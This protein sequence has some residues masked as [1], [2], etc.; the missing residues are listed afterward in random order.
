M[1]DPDTV[2]K[3]QH[4]AGQ[5]ASAEYLVLYS[6]RMY[7]TIPRLPDRYPAGAAYYRALFDGSLG[8]EL[9]YTAQKTP[10]LLGIAYD[11]DPFARIDIPPPEGFA[12]HRG[13][14]AT[15]GFGWA[16]ESFTVYDHPKVLVFRNTGRLDA[17]EIL[18]RI[19]DV[20]P[21]QPP[22]VRLLLSD[23]EAERQ[24]AGG[25]WT[26]V[27]FASG[28]P[29]G[30]TPFYWLLAA[31]AFGLAA[32]PLGLVVFRPLPDRGYLLIK[33]LGLLLVAAVAWLLVS[34]GVATFSRWS[35][36]V[37]LAIVGALSAAA[38]WRCRVEVS[39]FFRARWRHVVAMEVLFLVA[40]FAFLFV[41]S[42]NPDLW[43]PWRGGEKPMDFAYLNAVAR[44]TVMPPYDPWF[45]GGYLN[46]YYFGQ[47]IVASLIRVTGIAPSVAYN[48]AVPLLFALV[49]GGTF[50]IAYSLAEGARRVTG[51]D[52]PPRW[53]WSP[54]GA[55]LFAVVV[56]LIA[57]NM[58]GVT[59]LVLGARR[60]LLH[61][62]P[63]GAFDFWRSS[64]MMA[65]QVSGITE[66]PYF[67]FLFAD[68]HAHLI[69]IP[70]ALLAVGLSLA[71]FLRTGQPGR[72]WLETWG[73]LA[74]LGIVVGSLRI[75]NSW[76]YPTQLVIAAGAVVGGELLGGRR[77]APARPVAGIVKAGFAVLVGY[78][79]F[80]PFH[81]RF[82][83]F[84]SGV[85]VSRFQTPLW[86]YLAVHGVFIFILLGYLA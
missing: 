85:D 1:Y 59:Q 4:I 61:G 82:E 57:G 15:I 28:V 29:S 86:R 38:W 26:D 2:G 45:A 10:D 75:I 81:A 30:L 7:A 34:T 54:F 42:A 58:D 35:V 36:L 31:G 63:F 69:A 52:G 71:T 3:Y 13:A 39:L 77:D 62:E 23:E 74:L 67:T 50:S 60:V 41:R 5:L 66:F 9:A 16:D 76:D 25:T 73:C 83:L 24:R 6:N 46:Y 80:L 64:R 65:D 27:A 40:Y 32:L 70:F 68:L 33:A 43:H 51:C 37:A 56:V 55:G 84:N 79:V 17:G 12:R 53:L 11:D 72:S 18:D 14:L 44:S 19:G 47:F 21:V 22:G 49:A 8:Y 20:P 78:L 48:L